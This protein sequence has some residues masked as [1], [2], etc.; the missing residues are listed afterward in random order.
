MPT[1]H[2]WEYC[3]YYV[4]VIDWLGR[5]LRRIG[6]FQLCNSDAS[7]VVGPAEYVSHTTALDSASL[8]LTYAIYLS[9]IS[10]KNNP[11]SH[12]SLS[13]SR[14][15][16]N[17]FTSAVRREQQII[18]LS[19]FFGDDPIYGNSTFMTKFNRRFFLLQK[20]QF[21]MTSNYMYLENV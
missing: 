18:M 1:L 13:S 14:I 9:I 11:F 12:G 19:R 7:L 10:S 5:V 8:S 16:I 20:I 17:V 15:W 4:V 3:R 2:D 6:I 21:S